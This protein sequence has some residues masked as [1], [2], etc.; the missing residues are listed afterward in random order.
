MEKSE[1]IVYLANIKNADASALYEKFKDKIEPKRVERI[2]NCKNDNEKKLLTVTGVLLQGILAQ[3]GVA[4][5]MIGYG[6][7]GKPYVKNRGDVFY[8]VS[9]SGD[10]VMIAVAGQ[11]VGVDIQKPVPY[12]ETLVNKI[13]SFEERDKLGQEIVKHLNLVWAVK[14]S[15]TKLTGEGITRELAEIS[16]EKNDASLVIK[17]NG[18]DAAVGEVVYSD[19]LYE[20][21][22]A[23]REPFTISALNKMMI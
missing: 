10:Y 7:H 9:H 6:L 3:Q 2:E 17:D 11:P 12:K 19:D 18:H 4:A 13:C 22:I 21:V 1:A 8:N 14:E 16:F 23:A 15:Y 20:A 5:S